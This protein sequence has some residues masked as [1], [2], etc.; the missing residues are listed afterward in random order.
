MELCASIRIAVYGLVSRFALECKLEDCYSIGQFL[1]SQVMYANVDGSC[2]F[3]VGRQL[4][5]CTEI[6]SLLRHCRRSS[7][8]SSGLLCKVVTGHEIGSSEA[9]ARYSFSSS[10]QINH[11]GACAR[12][13]VVQ[14]SGYCGWA[15]YCANRWSFRVAAIIVVLVHFGRS[16]VLRH[17]C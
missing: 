6:C 16:I 14:V 17:R 13:G 15:N 11:T 3:Y 4:H 2:V 8:I 7:L 12:K 9:R 5:G 1:L 10:R